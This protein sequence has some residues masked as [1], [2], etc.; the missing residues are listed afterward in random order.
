M[1]RPAD[2]GCLPVPPVAGLISTRWTGPFVR[3]R[4]SPPPGSQGDR[5]L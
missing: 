2:V 4:A 3:S 5:Q 1:F